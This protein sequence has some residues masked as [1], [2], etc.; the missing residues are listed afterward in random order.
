[1]G[2]LR[3]GGTGARGDAVG[4]F[5]T[6]VQGVGARRRRQVPGVP[7]TLPTRGWRARRE[8]VAAVNEVPRGGRRGL[9]RGQ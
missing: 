7:G 2:A 5:P 9:G 3:R 8:T 1:V 4:A 6:A